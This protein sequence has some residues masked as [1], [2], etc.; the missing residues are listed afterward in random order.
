MLNPLREP[1]IRDIARHTCNTMPNNIPIETGLKMG[2]G[3]KKESVL[4]HPQFSLY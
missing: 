3:Q 1:S 2:C 4:L